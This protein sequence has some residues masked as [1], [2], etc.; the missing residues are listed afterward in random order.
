[1]TRM[2]PACAQWLRLP[3]APASELARLCDQ[4]SSRQRYRPSRRA[5]PTPG[6][7]AALPSYLNT[8]TAR[9]ALGVVLLFAVVAAVSRVRARPAASPES[10]LRDDHAA[11]GGQPPP[12][13]SSRGVPEPGVSDTEEGAAVPSEGAGVRRPPS[14]QRWSQRHVAHAP[15]EPVS[16]AVHPP[17]TALRTRAGLVAGESALRDADESSITPASGPST[18]PIGGGVSVGATHPHES[19][20]PRRLARPHGPGQSRRST[21][22]AGDDGSHGDRSSGVVLHELRSRTVTGRA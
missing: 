8:P 4:A 18:R 17:T 7:G 9:A 19:T 6:D 21:A 3:S 12:T 2:P 16:Y 14:A 22:A 5:I 10:P 20:H 11:A 13:R 1:M 15:A